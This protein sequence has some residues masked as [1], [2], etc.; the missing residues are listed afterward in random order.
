MR[1]AARVLAALGAAAGAVGLAYGCSSPQTNT[2]AFGEGCFRADDCADGMICQTISTTAQD[3]CVTD[4]GVGDGGV[5]S[6][7]TVPCKKTD[8]CG[9]TVPPQNRPRA[10]RHACN[11]AGT[12]CFWSGGP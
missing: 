6:I 2:R 1:T 11:D 4:G 3:G 9:G 7:C 10:C 8:D 5:V 12:V